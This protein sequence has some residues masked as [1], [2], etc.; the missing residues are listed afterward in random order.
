MRNMRLRISARR[1]GKVYRKVVRPAMING[2]DTNKK[3]EGQAG[4]AEFKIL[5][6]V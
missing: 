2:L 5:R 6:W 1:K 4:F 3:K